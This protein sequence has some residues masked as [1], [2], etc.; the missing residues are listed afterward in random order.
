MEK[1]DFK[2]QVLYLT[3]IGRKSGAPRRI[4]IWFVE[5]QGDVYL[6]TDDR[7]RS[8]WFRNVV[9]NPSATIEIGSRKWHAH[10]QVLDPETDTRLLDDV[11]RL[12]QEKYQWWSKNIIKFSLVEET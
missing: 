3:T 10:G 6:L 8:H 7:N 4:E 5:R 12:A 2:E 11:C 1:T 9:A